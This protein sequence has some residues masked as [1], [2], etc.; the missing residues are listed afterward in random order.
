MEINL[1]IFVLSYLETASWVTCDSD[2]NTNFTKEAM[3]I[4][5]N[6]C[7]KFIQAVR[8]EFGD[9]KA[10]ELLDTRGKDTTYLCAHDFFLTRNSHGAGFWDKPEYY[11]GQENADRLTKVAQSMGTADCIHVRGKKSKLTFA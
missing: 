11:G 9:D 1:K 5:E 7:I 2:E 10:K 4:A 8:A 3:F 6:Q